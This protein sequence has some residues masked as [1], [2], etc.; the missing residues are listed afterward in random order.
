MSGSVVQ[1]NMSQGGIP[2]LPVA[3]AVATT[4]G[5]DGDLHNNPTIHGGPKKAL[6]WITSEGIDE[7]RAA[8]FPL[9]AGA[10]GE[11]LTTRGVDRRLWRTGQ[12]WRI[13]EV[14]IE[15]TRMRT[16]CK[17]ITVYGAAIGEAVY[18][19][20]VKAGDPSSLRWGLSGFYASVVQPGTVR[21]GDAVALLDS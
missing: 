8:G 3:E 20:E 2:K 6:L 10:L 13:G 21:V 5:L 12:L 19:P 18:D 7:L 4:L 9:Y 14:V 17:T 11:N 15:L 16:P 1:L